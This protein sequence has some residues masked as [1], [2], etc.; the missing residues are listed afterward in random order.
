MLLLVH[1]RHVCLVKDLECVDF[2]SVEVLDQIDA[3]EASD[4]EC[5]DC[6]EIVQLDVFRITIAENG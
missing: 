1:L 6:F 4:T 3:P 5:C 2:L